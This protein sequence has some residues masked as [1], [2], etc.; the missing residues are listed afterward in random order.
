MTESRSSKLLAYWIGLG[1]VGTAVGYFVA[2]SE[3]PVIGTL[4]PLLFG[5]LGTGGI[6]ALGRMDVER[7]ASRAKLQR[8]GISLSV[9]AVA[10]V[11]SSAVALFVRNRQRV[12]TTDQIDFSGVSAAKGLELVALRRK[13]EILGAT[14]G[15]QKIVLGSAMA[16]R[17]HAAADPQS[18][19][20]YLRAVAEEAK[21]VSL[22][23]EPAVSGVSTDDEKKDW[24]EV[25]RLRQILTG[26]SALFERWSGGLGSAD[27]ALYSGIEIQLKFLEGRLDALVG[28]TEREETSSLERLSSAPE[29]LAGLLSLQATVAKNRPHLLAREVS[30]M[31]PQIADA[32][33]LVDRLIASPMSDKKTTVRYFATTTPLPAP[34]GA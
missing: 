6:V 15:E 22:L 3:S 21:R 16:E 1:L 2:L 25:A 11:A 18:V 26:T 32:D 31:P 23:I 19:R 33:T 27:E 4:L 17:R 5:I 7:E 10:I 14:P 8:V 24:E 30:G 9:F 13:L 12:S 29:L 34:G 20:S 28:S